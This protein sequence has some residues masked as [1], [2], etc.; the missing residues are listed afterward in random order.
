[1]KKLLLILL[2][3]PMFCFS[4]EYSEVVEVSGKTADQLYA[5]AREWFALTFKSANDVL[6]MDDSASGKLI[7]KGS[8]QVTEKYSTEGIVKVPMKID[9]YPS[10]TINIAFKDGKYKCELSDIKITSAINDQ[11]TDKDG[12]FS[13]Y[14]DQEEYFKNG[15]DPE[16]L[17][18]NTNGPKAAIKITAKTNEA[19]YNLIIKTESQLTNLLASLKQHMNKNEDD[20]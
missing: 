13:T 7:G 4:Q 10:F 19:Y 9:W 6:R 20:W 18:D 11:L 12:D 16:W 2:M 3:A 15:S 14:K 17:K 5:S 8:T 1:M